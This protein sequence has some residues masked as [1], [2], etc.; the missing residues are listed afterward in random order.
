MIGG[1]HS[2]QMLMMLGRRVKAA[3][4]GSVEARFHYGDNTD[5]ASKVSKPVDCYRRK[6][7]REL[8][9][10]RC[11]R[12]RSFPNRLREQHSNRTERST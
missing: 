6:T 4:S 1:V 3:L 10:W 2:G 11:P 5:R 12:T 8:G 9:I 7:N